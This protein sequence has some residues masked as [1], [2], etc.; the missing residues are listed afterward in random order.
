MHFIDILIPNSYY[1]VAT[2]PP[3]GKRIKAK[4]TFTLLIHLGNGVSITFFL[5]ICTQLSIST[6][7]EVV[8]TPGD[9]E[10]ILLAYLF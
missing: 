3:F 6:A 10:S 2:L 1:V 7:R 8:A 5:L 4:R 9:S